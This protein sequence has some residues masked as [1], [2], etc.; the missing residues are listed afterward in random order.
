MGKEYNI[1]KATGRCAACERE[2]AAG[3][4]YLATVIEAGD[5]LERRDYCTS[6][7]PPGEATG[8]ALAAW[9]SRVPQP[10]DKRKVFVDD[11]VLVS[12][13]ERLADAE[14]PAKVNFRFVLALVLMRKKRL[15]YDGRRTDETGRDVWRMHFRGDESTCE[16]TDPNMDEQKIAEVSEQLGQIMETDL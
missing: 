3:E 2:L 8:D 12:F 10:Q 16:V 6:C 11:D 4:A 13:F 7:R 14:D 15:V 1:S 5:D 9:R